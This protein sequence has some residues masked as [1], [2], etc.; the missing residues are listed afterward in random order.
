MT[1]KQKKEE[2]RKKIKEAKTEEEIAE[3]RKQVEIL[4]DL[5]EEETKTPEA[6]E[7]QDEVIDERNLLKGAEERLEKR[8]KDMT[9]ARE[10]EKPDKEERKVNEKE[11]IEQRAKDLKA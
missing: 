1:I 11:L 10:I 9:G 4:E 5:E 2:L 8:Q 3:L 6:P 7:N